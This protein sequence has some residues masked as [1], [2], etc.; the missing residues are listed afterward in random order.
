MSSMHSFQT[1]DGMWTIHC[2]EE[3]VHAQWRKGALWDQC[4]FASGK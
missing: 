3:E 2:F 4:T 1:W